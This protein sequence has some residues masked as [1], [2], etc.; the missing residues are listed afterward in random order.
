MS[1][2][3]VP[4]G[5]WLLFYTRG[6][7]RGGKSSSFSTSMVGKPITNTLGQLKEGKETRHRRMSRCGWCVSP[8]VV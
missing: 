8:W 4:K 5:S 3:S 2:M 1:C 6:S 7:Q